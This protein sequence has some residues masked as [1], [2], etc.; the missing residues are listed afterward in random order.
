[1]ALFN[2]IHIMKQA[3]KRRFWVSDGSVYK[4]LDS[5]CPLCGSERIKPLDGYEDCCGLARCSSCG[6][7]FATDIPDIQTTQSIYDNYG[8]NDYLSDITVKR[9]NE[10]L[11]LFEKYRNTNKILDIGCGIGYFLEVARARG[12]Q[13]YGT[14]FSKRAVEICANKGIIMHNGPITAETYSPEMFDVITS[15]EVIEHISIPND[16]MEFVPRFLRRHG[17]FYLTTPNF[18]SIVRIIQKSDWD[19]ISKKGHPEHLD[20]YT[21]KSSAKLLERYGLTKVYIHTE[22]ISISRLKRSFRKKSTDKQVRHEKYISA[23]SSDEKLRA[24]MESSR[25]KRLMKKII[26]RMLSLFGVGD[27]LKILAVKR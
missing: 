12:W 26:N 22:G 18:N 16:M 25:T 9:Y 15:F 5:Q 20:Y 11:D 3:L 17:A 6:L 1:M 21:R 10:L 24:A 2:K 13:V 19:V 7:V 14:E 27:T 23:T 8:R 4:Y